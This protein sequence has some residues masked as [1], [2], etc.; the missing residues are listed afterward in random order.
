MTAA[1]FV[2]ANA[3]VT[4]NNASL[5]P[6]IHASAVAHDDMYLYASI[7]N[8]SATVNTPAGWEV[9][10][11]DG[12]V[13]LF[14]REHSGSES[15]PTVSFTGGAAGDDTLAQIAVL[16]NAVP[17]GT[18]LGVF[19]G[20]SNTSAQNIAL[21]SAL[22]ANRNGSVNLMLGWKQD[23]W[24]SV[25]TLSG[26]T[27]IGETLSTAGNDAAQVWD[28]RIDTTAAATPA[29]P[30]TVTGGASAISKSY[31]IGLAQKAA[32]AVT[33]QDSYPPRNLISV[34][35][36]I[37]GDSV[38]IYRQ[39]LGVRTLVRAA[40]DTSVTDTSFLRVD[41]EFPFGVPVSYVA[42]VNGV[43]YTTSA[44]TYD[45]PGGNV[46]LSDAI[47]GGSAEVIIGEWPEKDYAKPFTGFQ[48]A[49]RNIVVS[50]ELGQFTGTV[51]LLTT[52]QSQ[53]ENVE[54]LLA[55][56]TGGIIQV[57][58]ADAVTYDDVD[59]YLSVTGYRKRRV[60]DNY[61]DKERLFDLDVLEV[62]G[63]PAT[64]EATG[65]TLQDIADFYGVNGT[66]ADID[67][68]FTSLLGIALGDFS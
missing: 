9:V 67:S 13:A 40:S 50:N 44:V 5:S 23:D 68:D 6:T 27:E 59:G 57:R 12:N 29:G 56:A 34:T 60:T 55:T 20:Q 18:T 8:T 49:G 45:L 17:A 65:F 35:N 36:L 33:P 42:D 22:T 48:V 66:L 25:A 31:L 64:Q 39:V 52:T 41:A 38:S 28:Y 10:F 30:F 43:E 61:A 51:T 21:P 37:V 54:N 2:G 4:G 14:Y 46:A 11:A 53:R 58:T 19:T 63:W 7:R 32:L 24:T 47:S 15:A 16:R 1:T 62:D 26:C 3:G